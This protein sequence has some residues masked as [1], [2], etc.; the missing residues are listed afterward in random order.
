M[1]TGLTGELYWIDQSNAKRALE[2]VIRLF[3]E[4]HY[5]M[6]SVVLVSKA[7][8]FGN[9]G[10]IT[11]AIDNEVTPNHAFLVLTQEKALTAS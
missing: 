7:P 2:K 11:V 9:V 10:N 8:G 4:K 6:P 3:A 1:K 5:Q